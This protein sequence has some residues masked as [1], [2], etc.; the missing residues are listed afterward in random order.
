MIACRISFFFIRKC[1]NFPVNNNNKSRIIFTGSG[2]IQFITQM[3][4][5]QLCLLIHCY[6]NYQTIVEFAMRNYPHK[7][8]IDYE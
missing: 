5:F 3:A 1:L 4:N 7:R 6:S 2:T 8:K